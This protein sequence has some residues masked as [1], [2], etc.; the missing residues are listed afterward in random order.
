MIKLLKIFCLS[1]VFQGVAIATPLSINGLQGTKENQ[2]NIV[3][4][5]VSWCP[6][7]K[8]TTNFLKRFATQNKEIAIS[9]LFVDEPAQISSDNQ[10]LHISSISL[11]EAKKYGVEKSIPYILIFDKSGKAIKRYHTFSPELLTKLVNNLKNG[12]YE[13][14]TPPLEQ[15]I[16]LWQ[17]NRF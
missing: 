8:E 5:V 2:I 7:C 9:F 13:N 1:L 12:L 11:Q 16:D 17:K 14:G 4:F 10:N 15:R 6:P 3:A